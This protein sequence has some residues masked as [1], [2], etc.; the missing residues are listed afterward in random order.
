MI[1]QLLDYE[2]TLFYAINGTHTW[3]LDYIMSAFSS[4]WIWFPMIIV[5]LSFWKKP[6][7]WKS[8]FVCTALTVICSGIVT[9]LIFKPL[10]HRFRP[11]NHPDFINHVTV[12]NNYLAN[13]AYGFISG[14]STTS[15]AFALLSA[16]VIKKRWYSLLI[17]TWATLMA[18]S[19]IYLG[20]HFISDVIPGI[21]VGLLLGW[22]LYLLYKKIIAEK[23]FL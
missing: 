9:S 14:H 10:F 3:W 5:P 18:Y 6:N 23:I 15:F 2:R 19:R 4:L 21:I 11:S 13:G 8:A 17:F 20:A 7:E 22:G 16:L 12:V 1:E